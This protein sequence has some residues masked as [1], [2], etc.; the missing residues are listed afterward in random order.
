MHQRIAELEGELAKGM[1]EGKERFYHDI[2]DSILDGISILD[3]DLNII[4][5]NHAIEEWYDHQMPLKGKKCFKAY[6]GRSEPC[7]VCPSIR[8]L[9]T[10][11]KDFDVVPMTGPE[12]VRGWLELYTFPLVDFRTGDVT[13]VIEYVRDITDRRRL[14]EEREKLISDLQEA[15]TEVK[16]LKVMI[17]ACAWNKKNQTKA[18]KQHYDY[19]LKQ[20]KCPECLKALRK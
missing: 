9:K 1:A 18:I 7:E 16:T 4:F 3:K 13:G 15:L 20:G 14:E 5:T 8:T 6:H 2:L 11:Q 19:V 12:G 10:G 17:P